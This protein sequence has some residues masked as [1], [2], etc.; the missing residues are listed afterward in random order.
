[1]NV[2]LPF[3]ITEAANG[4][5]Y[6]AH[7]HISASHYGTTPAAKKKLRQEIKRTVDAAL[8]THENNY[9]TKAIF[10]DDGAVFF[11][12]WVGGSWGYEIWRPGCISPSSTH[13]WDTFG[14]AIE[15]AERHASQCAKEKS[16]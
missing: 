14:E 1:M 15:A 2:T 3:E 10:A 4:L 9:Q 11:V 16:Q 12:R 13:A 8:E 6:A 5:H 7:P